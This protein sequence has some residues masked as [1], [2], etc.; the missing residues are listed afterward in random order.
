MGTRRSPVIEERIRRLRSERHIPH[1]LTSGPPAVK[2]PRF[3]SRESRPMKKLATLGIVSAALCICGGVR[4][5]LVGRADDRF[6]LRS[7]DGVAPGPVS[8][9]R[10]RARPPYPWPLRPR[11]PPNRPRSTTTT[12]RSSV[13]APVSTTSSAVGRL[14]ENSRSAREADVGCSVHL[15]ATAKDEDDVPTNPRYPVKWHYSNEDA[16]DVRGSNPM[17][18]IITGKVAARSGDLRAGGRRGLQQVQDPL[19]LGAPPVRD[20]CRRLRWRWVVRP[21]SGSGRTTR[22]TARSGP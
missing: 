13:S 20:A 17:G 22:C 10:P 15:D 14:L 11:S 1:G 21:F 6:H 19:P 4:L 16:I 7:G 8:R 12:A 5:R 2:V 18:P 9:P 3:A